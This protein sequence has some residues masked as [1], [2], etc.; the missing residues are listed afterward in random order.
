MG[1]QG[2]AF[3][4]NVRPL[5]AACTAIWLLFAPHGAAQD[6]L[7]DVIDVS[8]FRLELRPFVKLPA[9]RKNLI[10]MTTRPGDARLYATT[11]EGDVLVVNE[12]A[13]G[14]ATPSV[15]FRFA[16]A[17]SAAGRSMAGSSSQQGLQSVAFHPDFNKLGEPGYGK[18]YTTYLETR[19]ANAT[20]L[21]YLGHSASGANVNADGV[22]SEWTYDFGAGEVDSASF[23]ELFRV[24]M[25][26][27]EH[28]IKQ[29]RFNQLS[30]PGDDDYGLLYITH[31]DSNDKPS[32][33]L[34]KCRRACLHRCRKS[35]PSLCSENARSA[36]CAARLTKY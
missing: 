9:N 6:L 33:T 32:I 21:H 17:L 5:C 8:D 22:L 23:R 34:H 14:V 28:P 27:L 13:E 31:G 12:D 35:A 2:A 25:P 1:S 10:S 16:T 26:V 20:G 11:Q 19:P 3:R 30:K 7:N 24:R 15:F 18:L 4:L 36:D 29:A